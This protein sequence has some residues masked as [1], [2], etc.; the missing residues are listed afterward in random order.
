MTF[1]NQKTQ[2]LGVK[3]IKTTQVIY[4]THLS[5][6]HFNQKSIPGRA[7]QPECVLVR[8]KLD[9]RYLQESRARSF[10]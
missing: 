6:L 3:S 8:I 5:Q 10:I 9:L 4:M 1:L 7:K 2:H